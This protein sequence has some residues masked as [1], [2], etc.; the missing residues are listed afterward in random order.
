MNSSNSRYIEMELPLDA[1]KLIEIGPT[2]D[3]NR[4]MMSVAK[5]LK[6]K[7]KDFKA[8]TFYSSE[9]PYCP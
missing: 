1:L 8:L 2:A 5:L 4:Q 7:V 9:I 3:K 6:E